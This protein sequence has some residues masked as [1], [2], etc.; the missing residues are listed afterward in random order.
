MS[1]VQTSRQRGNLNLS[2]VFF[3]IIITNPM[4]HGLVI[5]FYYLHLGS[6]KQLIMFG[7]APSH[8]YEDY[9]DIMK[10]YSFVTEQIDWRDEADTL[11]K[12]VNFKH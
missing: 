6:I 5:N 1:L 3:A 11:N 4:N 8:Q 7:D 12:M 9:V 2:N 10:T